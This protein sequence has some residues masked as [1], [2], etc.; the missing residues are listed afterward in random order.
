MPI[1]LSKPEPEANTLR[2]SEPNA[3]ILDT[4]DKLVVFSNV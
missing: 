3:S 1:I 4:D 2:S